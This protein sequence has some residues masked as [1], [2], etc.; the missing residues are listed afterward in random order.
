MTKNPH[1]RMEHSTSR[2]RRPGRR[3]LLGFGAL[4]GVAG[5]GW[6][7]AA[8]WPHDQPDVNRL[9]RAL[10][11]GDFATAPVSDGDRPDAARVHRAVLGGFI[12]SLGSPPRIRSGR[13]HDSSDGGRAVD[14]HWSWP[15]PDP[16]PAWDYT[17][18]AVFHR[19]QGH[20][21]TEVSP[22]L[23]VD[24]LRRT[25]ALV[26][27]RDAPVIG[28]IV[29]SLG[30]QI[31]GPLS[32]REIGLDKS[33]ISAEEAQRS[34]TRLAT[35]LRIDPARYAAQ[36][37][38]NGPK[39]YVPA[40]TI[41]ETAA[42]EYDLEATAAV[43]GYLERRASRP[44][45]L[46]K[47]FA[48]GVLGTIRPATAEDLAKAGTRLRPGDL[49]ASGGICGARA[50]QLL[51]TPG[52]DVIAR[53]PGSDSGRVIVSRP[54]VDGVEVSTT[55]DSSVQ[56]MATALIESA[57]SPSAIIAMQPSNGH[58][59]AAALGPTA[60]AYPVGLIG[61]YAPGSTFKAVT[62]LALLR[63][64]MTA[65]SVL[66][67]PATATLAGRSF[68]N[69][70]RMD[71]SLFGPMPLK[72]VIAHSCNTALLLQHQRVSQKTLTEA[73]R[74]LGLMQ[75]SPTGLTAFMGTVD[76]AD[77]DAEHAADMMG[78]GRVL[79]S[80]LAMTTAMAS[81]VAGRTVRPRILADDKTPVS[82]VPSTALTENEA[83]ALRA[84]LRGVTTYGGLAQTFH[85]FPGDPVLA[86]TGT[87]QW[88]GKDGSMH[89]H[90]WVIVAQGDLAA[91]V[92]VEDGD[93]GSTTAGPLAKRFLERF[94]GR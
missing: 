26:L 88:A 71:P 89:L 77:A 72:D 32:V 42:S 54:R 48:P 8:L 79:A 93:Y 74:A 59:L 38:K 63:T 62:A 53:R 67:C 80:P 78:Q 47:N 70:D 66:D 20:W 55:L 2:G 60:Q 33:T 5:G 16:A 18:T 56:E 25:E 69:A 29:D 12:A 41:R 6:A 91:A 34:A 44:L 13:A 11:T 7:T 94:H 1:A 76:P 39:A 46:R 65:D 86:K 73:A 92:F 4:A 61:Q 22:E 17:T 81:I 83:S 10:V 51:G 84:M 57:G 36:V 50:R 58:V 35:L 43:P 31:F 30:N 3:A 9:V 27:K 28:S 19:A 45:P 75:D 52:V 37:S 14:L 23:L 85:G 64:G 49:L 24:G 15:L 90:S 82:P 68:K 40:L 87:A 21:V